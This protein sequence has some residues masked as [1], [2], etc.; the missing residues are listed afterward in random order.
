MMRE[1]TQ[2]AAAGTRTRAGRPRGFE[3]TAV[4]DTV[5]ARFH[6]FG[7]HA[8]SISDLLAVTGLHKGSLYAAFG[9]KYELFIRVLT[10]YADRR[11]ELLEADLSGEASP[12]AG[13]RAYLGRQAA[14]AVQG[15]GCL[16]AN[17]ALELLP[18]DPEVLRVLTRQHQRF[19]SRLL[20]ALRAAAAL[21]EIDATRARP[22]YARCLFAMIEGL[23][24]LGRATTEVEPILDAALTLLHP[25]A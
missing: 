14:E 17:S 24:E 7:Y 2:T 21:D 6:S 19:Q 23:W 10:R 3:E 1:M 5:E 25:T 4:L 20:D 18:G 13:I 8:T 15:R 9:G 22:E 12:L 16:L 11:F